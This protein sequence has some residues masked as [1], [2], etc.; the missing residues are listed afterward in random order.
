MSIKDDVMEVSENNVTIAENLEKVYNAGMRAGL[1]QDPDYAEGYD[2][3]YEQ[4]LTDSSGVV[5]EDLLSGKVPVGKAKEADHADKATN[6]ENA[7]NAKNANHAKSADNATNANRAT[8]ANHATEADHSVEADHATEAGHSTNAD[9]AT[10]ADKANTAVSADHAT[11]ATL[12]NSTNSFNGVLPIEEG[13][14]GANNPIDALK[15]LGQKPWDVNENVGSI[16]ANEIT[17]GDIKR[18][19]SSEV[20][21]GNMRIKTYD[22]VQFP[23]INSGEI[24]LHYYSNIYG[25]SGDGS[26]GAYTGYKVLK[27][28]EVVHSEQ[29]YFESGRDTLRTLNGYKKLKLSVSKGDIIRIVTECKIHKDNDGGVVGEN[30]FTHIYLSANIDT[31]YKYIALVDRKDTDMEEI[32]NT[33]LGV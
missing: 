6:A 30:L 14:T 28:D 33:L 27:N 9:H 16:V 21:D 18:S 7:E 31:P 4:G 15:N 26:P 3:G 20:A 32:I 13:G 17:Y 5:W 19:L 12:A 23:M 10:N 25:T 8:G 24:Y 2:D 1:A 22:V 29:V 11:T